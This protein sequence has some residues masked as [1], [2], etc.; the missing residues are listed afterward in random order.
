MKQ[1]T[2]IIILFFVAVNAFANKDEDPE[3]GRIRQFDVDFKKLATDPGAEAVVL[4]DI[5]Y[6]RFADTE[7]GYEINFRRHRRIKILK[8]A[9]LEYA[10]IV[11]PYYRESIHRTEDVVDIKVETFN[12]ENGQF[13]RDVITRKNI[14]DEKQNKYWRV[15]KVAANNVKVGSIIDITYTLR[16]PFHFNLPDWEF[17][18]SIPTLLSKYTV[19]MIPFY[20]Y[21]FVTQGIKSFDIYKNKKSISQR[22]FRTMN[23]NDMNYTYGMKNVPAF[24]DESFITSREDYIMK[25]DFQLSKFYS[26]SGAV[27]DIMSSWPELAKSFMKDQNF[28]RYIKSSTNIAKKMLLGELN[29]S[30]KTDHEKAVAIIQYVKT[31]F[32]WNNYNSKKATQK[33]KDFFA[34]KEGN[35]AEINLFMIG[36]FKAAG[37]NTAPVMMSTRSHGKLYTKYPFASNLNYVLPFVKT[38]KTQFLTDGTETLLRYNEIPLRCINEIGLLLDKEEEKWIPLKSQKVS[39]IKDVIKI[40]DIDTEAHKAEV[41]LSIATTGHDA[42]ESRQNY[43]TEQD[44]IDYYQSNTID[45]IGEIKNTN[46]TELKKPH[47]ISFNAQTE[48]SQLG[49]R[50]IVRPFLNLPPRKNYFT[51]PKR[52]YPVDFVYQK[53]REFIATIEIPEGYTLSKTPSDIKMDNEIISLDYKCLTNSKNIT[54]IGSYSFKKALYK[55]QDY[56][57]LRHY[58]KGVISTLNKELVFKKQ[59]S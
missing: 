42:F 34:K 31:N 40:H 11:I 51:Q 20:T 54:V 33:A 2:L 9:G 23:F 50:L 16:S 52:T 26:P 22:H 19:G 21:I 41:T 5:G 59:E 4:F 45:E 55:S 53:R 8:K 3:F 27:T 17:Q 57:K 44:V 46:R 10:Q 1:V 47:V 6:S 28:G 32:T 13:S 35:A 29:L 49:D 7:S 58:W 18:S 56:G 36:M 37:V 39:V 12:Y 15:K 30:G 24:K 25:I 43:K 48:V 38:E 14:F